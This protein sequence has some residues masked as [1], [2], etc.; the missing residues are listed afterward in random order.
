[1]DEESAGTSEKFQK[2]LRIPFHQTST[3][4][5][6]KRR[7]A[8]LSGKRGEKHSML[9]GPVPYKKPAMHTLVSMAGLTVS[10]PTPRKLNK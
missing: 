6:S 10:C 8:G 7:T 2:C 5:T 9:L 3:T 1:M 4:A